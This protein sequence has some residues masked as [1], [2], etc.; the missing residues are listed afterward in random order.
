MYRNYDGNRS[1][2]GA[3][4]VS[5]DVPNPDELSAFAA[6][7]TADNALTVMVINKVLSGS[8]PVTLNLAN[9]PAGGTAQVYQLTAANAINRLADLTPSG[10]ILS[11]TV[12]S[13]SITLFVVSNSGQ[14]LNKPPVAVMSATPISGVAPVAVAFSANGST[15]HDGQ[16]ASFLWNFGN[17]VTATGP[18]ASYTYTIPGTYTATLAVTDNAG[19]VATAS[20]TVTVA[21]PPPPPG[22]CAVKY[23]IVNDWKSGFLSDIIVTNDTSKPV[24]GWSLRWSFNGNQTITNLW[25]GVTTQSGQTVSVK[26]AV[27]NANIPVGGNVKM[28]FVANYAG[29]NLKPAAFTLNGVACAVQ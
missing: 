15:D 29:T 4:S 22:S 2:F 9:F 20:K 11:T 12:P 8:T 27:W 24:N 5:A 1:S 25:N 16:I 3:T 10:Q 19:A 18:S 7:R 28:G 23:I 13:Q 26:D 17:G 14:P 21:E 6:V